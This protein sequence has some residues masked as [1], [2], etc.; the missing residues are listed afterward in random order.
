MTPPSLSIGGSWLARQGGPWHTGKGLE[1]TQKY[2]WLSGISLIIHWDMA[3]WP[4]L[5]SFEWIR[6]IRIHWVESRLKIDVLWFA[7]HVEFLMPRGVWK[8]GGQTCKCKTHLPSR[9]KMDVEWYYIFCNWNQSYVGIYHKYSELKISFGKLV[10]LVQSHLNL[11][12]VWELSEE[13]KNLASSQK[14]MHFPVKSK[15]F[16]CLGQISC[17][18]P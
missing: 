4:L 15:D 16:A 6:I 5:N 10:D 11:K 12:M 18:R 17:F 1:T 3:N 9:A 2:F 14:K 13:S 8:L 7:W